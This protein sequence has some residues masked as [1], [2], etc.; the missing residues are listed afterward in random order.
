MLGSLPKLMSFQASLYSATVSDDGTSQHLDLVRTG[1]LG[2]RI[3]SLH[4]TLNAGYARLIPETRIDFQRQWHALSIDEHQG[5]AQPGSSS[6]TKTGFRTTRVASV[7]RIGDAL[8]IQV[9]FISEGASL[10]LS[11]GVRLWVPVHPTCAPAIA[12]APAT[13]SRPTG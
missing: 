10:V 11:C 7:T 12:L 2:A 4:A 13:D 9:P 6:S 1:K 3:C 8:R 5:I